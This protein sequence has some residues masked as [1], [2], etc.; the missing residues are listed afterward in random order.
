MFRGNQYQRNIKYLYNRQSYIAFIGATLCFELAP[1]QGSRKVLKSNMLLSG[2]AFQMSSR[3]EAL[4][5]RG[6]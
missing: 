3:I 5:P 6:P 4:S 1:N 2:V